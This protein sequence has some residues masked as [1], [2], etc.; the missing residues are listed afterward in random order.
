MEKLTWRQRW[1]I[2]LFLAIAGAAYLWAALSGQIANFSSQEDSSLLVLAYVTAAAF[3]GA[4]IAGIIVASGF[5][6]AGPA[7]W[8]LAYI[9]GAVATLLGGAFGGTFILPVYGTITGPFVVVG[10]ARN[11]PWLFL[12]WAVLMAAV[13]LAAARLRSGGRTDAAPS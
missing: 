7:G 6:R 13:H 8:I 10:Y 5:G 1:T 4:G 2:A 11:N 3:L 12:V 9:S